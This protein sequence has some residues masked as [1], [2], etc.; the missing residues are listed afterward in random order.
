[1]NSRQSRVAVLTGASGY[2]GGLILEEVCATFSTVR[3]VSR[4]PSK[5]TDLPPNAIP[6]KADLLEFS[7]TRAALEDADIAFY[8]AH[9][10]ADSD[11]FSEL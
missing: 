3:Y 5:L 7:E 1:M 11:Q 4:D 10:M 6:T 8:F 9:S 2:V